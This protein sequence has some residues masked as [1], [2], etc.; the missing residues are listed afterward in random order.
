MILQVFYEQERGS[1]RSRNALPL[2]MLL[3]VSRWFAALVLLLLRTIV[4]IV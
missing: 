1:S 4:H 2:L 3:H